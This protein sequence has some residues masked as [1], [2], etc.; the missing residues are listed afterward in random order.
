M[1]SHERVS[2]SGE[3][4]VAEYRKNAETLARDGLYDPSQEHD[5]CGVGL[6]AAIDGKPRREVVT[7]GIAALKARVASRRRGCRR[8][9]RRRRRH[10]RADPAGLLPG[11]HPRPGPRAGRGPARRR[12]DLPAAHRSR[13]TG[14]LPLHRRGRDPRHAATAS[15]AGA[16]CRSNIAVIGEKANATRPEIEQIMINNTKADECQAVRDRSLHHPPAH[17]EAGASPRASRTSTSARSPAARSSTRACSWPSSSPPSIPTCST[18]ASSRISPS[19]TSAIRPTPSR[20]GGWRSPS[21]CSPTTARSIRCCGNINWM[22]AHETRMAHEIVRPPH[23]GPQAGRPA[24]RLG[25][26]GARCGVRGHGARGP[27]RCP[28]SRPSWCPRPG[29][30]TRAMPQAHRGHL[31]LLQRG[32]GA[33]GR[34]G[35]DLR[36]SAG[37]GRSP[38]WIATACAPC[39][40][41]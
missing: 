18:S 35:G 37:N 28:W 5:A 1:A 6:V 21:A 8:Q 19:T 25:F 10:P 15:T 30:T 11:A 7:A 3:R 20:P 27:Q 14:A 34:P 40:T 31:L 39:A 16:R 29:R 32:H 9:D 13:R 23:G 12:H 36:L 24:G 2:E 17:R 38:A 33:V 22:K 41:P 26:R 4:F